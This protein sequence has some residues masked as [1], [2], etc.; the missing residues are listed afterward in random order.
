MTDRDA[1][2]AN[3]RLT[4]HCDVARGVAADWFDDR[5]E[6]RIAAELRELPPGAESGGY[7]GGGGG[8][9]GRSSA[10]ANFAGAGG[11]GGKG[12]VIVITYF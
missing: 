10:I 1:I 8:G 5:G 12:V 9:G 2:L 3:V 11:A 4:P 6:R 7:G